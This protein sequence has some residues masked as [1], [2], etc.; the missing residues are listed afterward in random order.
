DNSNPTNLYGGLQDNG[1][2]RTTTG[3]LDDWYD[4]IWGDGFYVLVDPSDNSY[5]YAESQYGALQKSTNG[6]TFF[7]DATNGITSTRRNWNS[8]LAFNPQNPKSLY[9]GTN[10]LY[11]TVNRANHWNAI[12]DD[13]TN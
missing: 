9:F 11:K 4:I 3:N 5:Q 10:K 1:V 12:S 13:L 7:S 6:G 2:Q 8:P